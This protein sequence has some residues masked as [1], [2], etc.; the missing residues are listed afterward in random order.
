[1][2]VKNF[3]IRRRYLNGFGNQ[4]VIIE[5]YD[6]DRGLVIM[7]GDEI[8]EKMMARF[9]GMV[10]GVEMAGYIVNLERTIEIDETNGATRISVID[11]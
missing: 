8:A 4:P 11:I 1:M 2:L 5:I 3:E 10:T 6:L 7:T 9:E